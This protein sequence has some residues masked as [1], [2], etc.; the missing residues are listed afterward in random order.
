MPK[1]YRRRYRKRTWG[2]RRRGLFKRRY[3]RR[4]SRYS[5]K[6]QVYGTISKIRRPLITDRLFVKLKWNGTLF[7]NSASSLSASTYVLANDLYNPTDPSNAAAANNV[8]GY[9]AYLTL[10]SRYTVKGCKINATFMNNDQL[11]QKVFIQP[12]FAS[13][14][15]WSPSVFQPE[16]VPRTTIRYLSNNTSGQKA[17]IKQYYSTSNICGVKDTM[18]NEDLQAF[19]R[20]S[21]NGV[22]PFDFWG[23]LIAGIKQDGADT[24]T[25]T[26]STTINVTLTYYV[27]FHQPTATLNN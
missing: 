15:A 20:P 14:G 26:I 24:P 13:A 18:D 2:R 16:E 10:F 21:I 8:T 23:F 3:Y 17:S 19:T 9:N 4:R 27:V 12:R 25:A 5:K 11:P 6:R 7:F 22:R 1:T